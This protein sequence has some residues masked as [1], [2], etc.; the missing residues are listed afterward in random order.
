MKING[1]FVLREVVG[2]TILVPVG[3]TALKFNGMIT[4]NEI[5]GLIWKA[6]QE[7]KA[8]EEI[9]D[10]IMDEYEVSREEAKKDMEEFLK[11]LIEQGFISE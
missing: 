11:G 6:I 4:M 5:G 10:Q 1:E 2:E 9:L 3:E 7:D 8:E